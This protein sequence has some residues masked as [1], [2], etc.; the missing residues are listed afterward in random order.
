[1]FLLALLLSLSRRRSSVGLAASAFARCVS[2]PA[3][4]DENGKAQAG[5]V[6]GPGSQSDLAGKP[7]RTRSSDFQLFIMPPS[8]AEVPRTELH[9]V[10]AWSYQSGPL[11]AQRASG[12]PCVQQK[13]GSW[14]GHCPGGWAVSCIPEPQ[15]WTASLYLSLM[16]IL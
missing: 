1:M 4:T 16:A 10:S 11:C 9:Q 12:H 7:V 3:S 8:S 6:S 15:L 2:F 5:T 13:M 14:G